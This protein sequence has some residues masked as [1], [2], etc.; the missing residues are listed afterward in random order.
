MSLESGTSTFPKFGRVE[1]TPQTWVA[2]PG[3]FSPQGG[4]VMQRETSH[5]SKMARPACLDFRWTSSQ[6][7][8]NSGTLG[9]STPQE[10]IPC[11]RLMTFITSLPVLVVPS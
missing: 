3:R 5:A 11:W 7:V 6:R 4:S 9:S 8:T 10:D 2:S 1:V